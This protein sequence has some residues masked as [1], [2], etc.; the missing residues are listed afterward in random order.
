[1]TASPMR[2]A[3]LCA[4]LATSALAVPALA[5]SS[6]DQPAP[7]RG[8]NVDANGVDLVTG[9]FYMSSTEVSIGA[10]DGSGLSYSRNRRE[11]GYDDQYLTALNQIGSVITVSIGAL[12]DT[13]ASTAGDSTSGT[14]AKLTVAAGQYR[15]TTQD[16]VIYQFSNAVR[17]ERYRKAQQRATSIAFPDG[18]VLTIEYAT[19][20][21]QFCKFWDECYEFYQFTRPRTVSSTDGYRLVL[22][23]ASDDPGNNSSTQAAK[24]MTLASAT[25]TNTAEEFCT[26]TNC[27]P[28]GG[29][30][31]SAQYAW[32][33][34]SSQETR[35][36]A[37]GR[38]TTLT[39][40]GG[41]ITGIR[42]PGASADHVTITYD[43]AGRVAAYKIGNDIWT[44]SYTDAGGIRT[45]IVTSPTGLV[46]TVK[47]DLAKGKVTE[48]KTGTGGLTRYEYDA[49]TRLT[50]VI[51]PEGDFTTYGYDARDN[52]TSAVI[53]PKAGPA[54]TPISVAAAFPATCA[55]VLTCNKPTNTTDARGNVT[56]YSYAAEHGGMLSVTRPAPV[57][58]AARP[59][60]R[61]TY[62]QLYARYK[63]A[64]GTLVQATSPI[65]KL[66]EVSACATGTAPSCIGTADET[67]TIIDYG[68]PASANNLLPVSITVRSGNTGSAG[69]VSAT[70]MMS[71]DRYGNL[72]AV[73]GP[74]AG[75]EDPATAATT[76]RA[77][78]WARSRP[79]PTA[80]ARSSGA[81]RA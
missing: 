62:A 44:Y 66:T 12:S 78:W 10:G 37:M 49:E 48:D 67:R 11:L 51:R 52:V 34:T 55:N 8:Y 63:D 35:T 77:R 19:E 60:T 41:R 81:R 79:I 45:S 50:K 30:W 65:W 61:Y 73:D 32:N 31:R 54:L 40:S 38:V 16:G 24:W 75:A 42:P 20:V 9:K 28:T 26:T 1:M 43:T 33:G 14:G 36:D 57:A 47:S 76:R 4:L 80:R 6:A 70:S 39:V 27:P 18:R 13:F 56:D 25:A 64:A 69:A 74:L 59:Q 23:Y 2:A 29:T 15:Y 71:Y 46:R 5:Q 17:S 7:P 3:L 58:G 72:V 21:Q 53:T 22:R 68:S